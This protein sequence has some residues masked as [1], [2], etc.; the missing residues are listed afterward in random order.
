MSR[1]LLRKLE[2]N[3]FP[4]IWIYLLLSSGSV[5][6]QECASPFAQAPASL[7]T[8]TAQLQWISSTSDTFD[9]ELTAESDTSMYEIVTG[10]SFLW[11]GLLPA[12]DY[13]FRVRA[14]CDGSVSDWSNLVRFSTHLPNPTSCDVHLNI[15]NNYCGSSN[16][17][18]IDVDN[19]AGQQL[20][21]DVV[22]QEVRLLLA[23]T[24]DYDL[25]ISLIAPDGTTVL[26]SERNGA[27]FNNYGNPY[28]STCQEVTVFV[29]DFCAPRIRDFVATINDT[30]NYVGRFR[31]E[32]PLSIINRTGLDPNDAWKLKICDAQVSDLGSLEFAELVFLPIECTH[33]SSPSLGL[34]GGSFAE[35]EWEMGMSSD[36]VIVEY[37]TSDFVPGNG[38]H[39]GGGDDIVALSGALQNITLTGLQSSTK[40][41]VYL[42]TKCGNTY[43]SNTCFYFTTECADVSFFTDFDDLSSCTAKCNTPCLLTGVWQNTPNDDNDWVVRLGKTP[44]FNTG[45]DS[46][47]S[48]SGN[49]VYTET[50]YPCGSGALSILQSN[51]IF[52]DNNV[53]TDCAFSFQTHLKGATIGSLSLLAYSVSA[54]TWDTLWTV[55]GAQGD[56]WQKYYIDLS[57]YAGQTIQLRF[58]GIRGGST[59]DMALDELI[60]YGNTIDLGVPDVF[61]ADVDGDGYGDANNQTSFCGSIPPVGYV[62]DDTDCD[63][64]AA[65]TYPAAPEIKCNQI[66]ENCN[67]LEDDAILDNPMVNSAYSFCE[68]TSYHINLNTSPVGN[69]Y[70]YD[71]AGLIGIGPDVTLSNL[72]DGQIIYVI[73]SATINT[74][75]TCKS[76]LV[77]VSIQINTNPNIGE[78]TI[79]SHCSG[80][81]FSITSLSFEDAN[82]QEI[83]TK[84]YGSLPLVNANLLNIDTIFSEDYSAI[85][86]QAITAKGCRD[87]VQMDFNVLQSPEVKI[88]PI[89]DTFELC[90]DEFE[91]VTGGILS[92]EAPFTYLWS[93]GFDSQIALAQISSAS[94]TY[95]ELSVKLVDSTGCSA[96]DTVY[97]G[98]NAVVTGIAIN[99]LQDVSSCGGSDGHFEVVPQGGIPP[100]NISWT[101]PVSG[102]AQNVSSILIDGL[103]QGAYNLEISDSSPAG[104]SISFSGIII[105]SPGL[106]VNIDTVIDVSCYADFN[107]A[108][109]LDV[110]GSNPSFLWSDGDTN[111]DRTGLAAGSYSV[112]IAD[113][114]CS[115]SLENIKILEPDVVRVF[116]AQQEGISCYGADD[117]MIELNVFGGVKPYVYHW[118][119]PMVVSADSITSLVPGTYECVVEDANGCIA[120]SVQVEIEEPDSLGFTADLT[121]LA[122]HGDHSGAIVVNPF[123]GIENYTYA[124]SDP[125][126]QGR[127]NQALIAGDYH[128][129]I[130]DAHGCTA[131]SEMILSEPTAIQLDSITIQHPTCQGVDNGLLEAFGHGG[132]GALA[133]F[134]EGFP[135]GPMIENLAS[136]AYRLILKDTVG[137]IT[138]SLVLQLSV[139]K[140]VQLDI[141]SIHQV[142]C[143]GVSDGFVSIIP[144]GG[145]LPFQF[146]WGGGIQ[147]A[148]L[149][150]TSAGYYSV[151]V[152][153]DIGCWA[154]MDS[155]E[156]TEPAPLVLDLI[157]ALV[158]CF[159][160]S[161]G[162]VLGYV[163]GGTMP[164][165]Y[166]WNTGDTIREI[167]EILSGGYNLT[168]TDNHECT[169]TGF[170]LVE[171]PDSM[172]AEIS[173]VDMVADCGLGASLGSINVDVSGGVLPYSF[174]WDNGD[175]TKNIS[176]LDTGIYKLDIIDQNGCAVFV[177]PITIYNTNDDF[178]ILPM[179]VDDIQC[180]GFGDGE[181]VAQGLGGTMPYNFNW[182]NGSTTSNNWLETPFDTVSQLTQGKYNL[183]I[184][185]SKGCTSVSDSITIVEPAFFHVN[186]DSTRHSPCGA[187]TDGQIFTT[188]IGGIGAY[189]YLWNTLSFEED[190]DSLAVGIY[191]VT[192]VDENDCVA[193]LPEPV[194]LESL[195]ENIDIFVDSISVQNCNDLG[196][197]SISIPLTV[198][199]P[200]FLWSN[201]DTTEDISN[202]LPGFY[203][204]TVT[205]ASGCSNSLDSIEVT[206]SQ[207]ALTL[208]LN[209]IHNVTC[210]GEADGLISVSVDTGIPPFT[211]YWS[212]NQSDSLSIDNLEAGEYSV[213]IVDGNSCVVVSGGLNVGSP[214]SLE[215]TV[216]ITDAIITQNGQILLNVTGGVSP[217][218]YSWDDSVHQT[219]NP[220][221]N[222][223]PGDYS[224]TVTDFNGCE[225]VLEPQTVGGVTGLNDIASQRLS[226][227]PNPTDGLFYVKWPSK[228]SVSLHVISMVGIRYRP[229]WVQDGELIEVHLEGIP[230][231]TYL[232][233]LTQKNGVKLLGLISL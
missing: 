59:G 199:A 170:A 99:N 109:S 68:N 140:K 134:W 123:G 112:T 208:V 26:L 210:F 213:T 20:G 69:Y 164:Y 141:D 218:L 52:I 107:G 58:E 176:N 2:L 219:T 41:Y 215:A 220:A 193:T 36:S 64:M 24:Y 32:E 192:V 93:N 227:F 96:F 161:S 6:S 209:S 172:V 150:D 207:N 232:V 120:A 104:C 27:E 47:V 111:E 146:D 106:V 139:L 189:H 19:V 195:V 61:Y 62:V 155:V 92:G 204:V 100:Y 98:N 89:I 25:T 74:N 212:N 197:I 194:V 186:L 30:T 84:V 83:L 46:D 60:F 49:Y 97:I 4:S 51:C 205:D 77:P 142:S 223:V 70:W 31:P 229:D 181:I 95:S 81:P 133:Y 38:N 127:I 103:T 131:A 78:D 125:L 53:A 37:G 85:Y 130:S 34:I 143:A 119:S 137:C 15:P 153:D 152:T 17:F 163:Q 91:V 7:S 9:L 101:G 42:R 102:N 175:T 67:G 166:E 200:Q 214:D 174:V 116:V 14:L 40:Y 167:V 82:G 16:E 231:G 178:V 168:V 149:S 8:T 22:L 21:V 196:A 184:T 198:N 94:G 48:G 217:Y 75:Y 73:D 160:E 39:L 87:T 76:S 158:Q 135:Q 138:D 206:A 57:A 13:T 115:L 177:K 5:F 88:F 228:E 148:F 230:S 132:E 55:V 33:I 29:D 151:T 80:Q 188:P 211:Y 86:Y 180:F 121:Q 154:T 224:V 66:D 145:I 169:Q 35:I 216:S 233:E 50:S 129:T 182:S 118:T 128:C 1:I 191:T 156:I 165:S 90:P 28:D 190:P 124:W 65:G 56:G 113:A 117:G 187:N 183:T 110:V 12:R 79:I 222:L 72:Q 202:L 10:T 122:C 23:H 157:P 203:S 43:G 45:P 144:S 179:Q 171:T 136:G 108:I 18:Y 225:I 185:D 201:A 105:N 147:S 54:N 226:V 3:I 221:V 114:S 44:S 159:G 63:D 71:D 126:I 162:S 11:A 173:H